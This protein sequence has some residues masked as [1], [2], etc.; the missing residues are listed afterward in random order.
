LHTR[1]DQKIPSLIF[2]SAV[3]TL[4]DTQ[5]QTVN[6]RFYLQVLKRLTLAVSRK[7]PQKRAAGA[8]AL[9]H[10]N[11][12]AHTA[13][14]CRSATTLLPWHGSVWLLV[15]PPVKNSVERAE[16]LRH[17]RNSEECDE[18]AAHHSKRLFQ[19][20]FPAVAGPLEAVCQLTRRVF[21]K[22]LNIFS[23]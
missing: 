17:W 6:Q 4:R 19:K 5:G 20:M 15:V 1:C 3:G 13:H 12:P 2:Y 14:S 11:A 9:H 23:H 16:I 7:R 18:Y 21:W 8:W 22:L 10:D